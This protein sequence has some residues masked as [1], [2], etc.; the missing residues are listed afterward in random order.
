MIQIPTFQ[1]NSAD[2]EQIIEL[3]IQLCTIRI[4]WNSRSGYFHFNI[5][6]PEGNEINSIKMIPDWL[7]LGTH[8]AHIVFS[9]DFM[10]LKDDQSL[11]NE[12]DYNDLGN[13]Y[14]L[15]YLTEEEA[16]AWRLANGL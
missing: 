1:A 8:Q 15:Y 7:I 10:I 16:E 13:G 9:G 2:F 12:I 5:V 3:N 6:D 14:N 4:Q 11:G